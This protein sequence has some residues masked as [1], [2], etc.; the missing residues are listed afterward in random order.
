MDTGREQCDCRKQT[1]RTKR[2]LTSYLINITVQCG[3]S[4]PTCSN[5]FFENMK[6]LFYIRKK[7]IGPH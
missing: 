2:K 4:E 6:K 7:A 1:W 3:I 5:V